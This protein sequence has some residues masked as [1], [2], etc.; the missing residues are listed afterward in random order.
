MVFDQVLQFI[1][2][3]GPFGVFIG[4]FLESSVV[5]I[6]SEVVLVGAGAIGLNLIEIAIYGG[7][8]SAF[9]GLVGYYIGKYIGR[10]FLDKFGRYFLITEEKLSFVDRWFKRWGDEAT[11]IA[12]LI[13]L[14]PFKVF[15]IAAGIAK[16]D[17]KKF[18][19]FTLIGAIPRSYLLALLGNK[20]LSSENLFIIIAFL[21]ILFIA[22]VLF[23]NF[24]L[25]RKKSKGI[26]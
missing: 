20:L 6:P 11:L 3:L 18:F 5:P 1:R 19:V 26:K 17:V 23:Q 9:G 24:V 22:V 13:P 2:D 10:W 4:M 21:I 25:V 14:I 8:G 12:R 15:S 7:I 16:M